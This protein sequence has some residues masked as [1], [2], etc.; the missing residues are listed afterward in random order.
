M[1]FQ[2]LTLIVLIIMTLNKA[3]LLKYFLKNMVAILKVEFQI[4]Y[5][6]AILFKKN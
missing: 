1:L 3:Y 5:H 4:S 6:L 2:N